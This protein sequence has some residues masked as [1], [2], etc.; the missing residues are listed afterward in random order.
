MRYTPPVLPPDLRQFYLP[1]A[2]STPAGHELE[3][4]PWVLGFAEVVFP[5]DKRKGT[6]HRTTVRL[7]ARPPQLGHPVDWDKAMPIKIEPASRPDS[8]A[9]WASVPETLDTGRKLAALEKMFADYLYATQ[10]IS[11]FENLALEMLSLPGEPL[12]TFKR[13]CRLAADNCCREGQELEK[14][15]FAPKIEAAKWSVGKGREAR[16]ARLE[17]DLQAKLDEIAERC[18]RLPD[19]AGAI[20]VKPRKTD[21]R[22]THFGLA[23]APFWRKMN[24]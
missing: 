22:V 19:E 23:W 2:G 21:I 17:A 8:P 12:E 7:L 9:R 10:R 4:Q 14:V 24:T 13:R 16:I 11:L 15:K 18:R 3:Y 5:I 6:E 20:Q 1:V